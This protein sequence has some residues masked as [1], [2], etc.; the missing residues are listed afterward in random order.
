MTEREFLGW[1]Y[2][3]AYKGLPARRNDWHLAQ[4]SL[5]TAKTFGGMKNVTLVDF[6][7]DPPAPPTIEDP[8]NEEEH[9][10]AAIIAFGFSPRKKTE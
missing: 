3:S 8:E 4:I 10:E 2:Y 5:I 9:L 7:L 1:W 6:L